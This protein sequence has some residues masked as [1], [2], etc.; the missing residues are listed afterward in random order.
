MKLI[1]PT[2]VTDSKL[3]S[4]NVTEN[5]YAAWSNSTTYTVGQKVIVIATH[6]IYECLINNKNKYP[7]DYTS[8][9]LPEW[10]DLGATNKWKMF[11]QSYHN[12]RALIKE[13]M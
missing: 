11:D 7:P 3:T 2:T 4:S 1:Q 12:R 9:T 6:K 5:D 8:G 13:Y 10:L